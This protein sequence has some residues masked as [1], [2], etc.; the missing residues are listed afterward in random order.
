MTK[1]ER[2]YP[3]IKRLRDDEGLTWREIGERLG[4][5]LKTAHEYYS[6][7][8]G[9][10]YAERQARYRATDFG[11]SDKPLRLNRHRASSA[12]PATD[13]LSA[14]PMNAPAPSG[15]GRDGQGA[16]AT[17][18][19]SVAVSSPPRQRAG[20]PDS[21]TAG[22]SSPPA[23]DRLGLVAPAGDPEFPCSGTARLAAGGLG[24]TDEL[25][26]PGGHPSGS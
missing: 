12:R 21:N 1:R 26:R 10:R 18:S 25:T 7:P 8:R 23:G 3:E 22:S 20:L 13:E 24:R 11:P 17:S 5:S 19:P 6:D 14:D 15:V 9:E 16:G 2:L 4:M